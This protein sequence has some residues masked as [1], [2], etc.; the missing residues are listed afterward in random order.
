[1]GV[2]PGGDTGGRSGKQD[3]RR[4]I[5]DLSADTIRVRKSSHVRTPCCRVVTFRYTLEEQNSSGIH[6]GHGLSLVLSAPFP[7]DIPPYPQCTADDCKGPFVRKGVHQ[8]QFGIW[9]GKAQ[10]GD[11]GIRVGFERSKC[12]VV[13]SGESVGGLMH[14]PCMRS[15]G[16]EDH[17][18]TRSGAES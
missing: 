8:I 13:T 14:C 6:H 17:K 7:P 16:W 15:S 11:V 3:M 1:M 18:Q 9:K 12:P 10:R 2:I 4:R 5:G